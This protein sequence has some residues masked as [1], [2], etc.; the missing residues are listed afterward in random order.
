[1][2][3]ELADRLDRWVGEGRFRS[4]SDAVRTILARYEELEKTR[5]FYRMLVGR[6]R[7]ARDHPEGLVAL[8]P[9]E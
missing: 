8:G 7:E 6:S 1:M 4:R 3:E 9:S 5:D 2:S